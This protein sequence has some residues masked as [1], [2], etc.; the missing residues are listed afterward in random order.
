V[1]SGR[2]STDRVE[3][4]WAAVT[5]QIAAIAGFYTLVLAVGLR[6]ARTERKE[7]STGNLLLAGRKMP[8][9]VGIFTMTATWVGGGYI[10]G[11]AEAVYSRSQGLVWAQAPWGYAL[12]LVLG[13][14]FFAKPMRRAGYTTLLDP[15]AARYDRR[16]AAVLFFPALLGEV[17]WSAAILL[18][19]GTTF[20]A[21]F[22]L[23]FELSI[24]VSAAVAV[25]YTLCGGLWSVAWTD[26][27]Q[28]GLIAIGLGLAIPFAYGGAGGFEHVTMTYW[29]QMPAFPQGIQI[30]PWLDAALMLIL[31]GIPWQVYFQRVLACRTP[32]AAARLSVG[33][34]IASLL[35]ALPAIGL[36]MVASVVDWSVVG[37]EPPPSDAVVLPYALKYL[38][39]PAVALL[40]LGAISAAV[41][42]SVDS[43][44]LSAS[45]LFTWNVYRPLFRPGATDRQ[46]RRTLRT[47]I[48]LVGTLGTLLA[49]RLQSVYALWFL[50]ADL[51]YVILFP[52]L[53]TALFARRTSSAGAIA[54]AAV[55]L[56]ARL[57]G[58]VPE[59]GLPCWFE[60]PWQAELGDSLPVRTIA[61]LSSWLTIVVVSRMR[62]PTQR[63]SPRGAPG[64]VEAARDVVEGKQQRGDEESAMGIGELQEQQGDG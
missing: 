14:W 50:C 7:D 42:S 34:G 48:V 52:Q 24:I 46:L 10:N 57:C 43:S 12:S 3:G 32:Q 38:T 51:A 64:K 22:D 31:G 59:L 36:G 45:S 18:A 39:P 58:G 8:L 26:V 6:A 63:W 49:L 21:V 5:Y 62:P 11:T 47:T 28:L 17:F 20:A 41:M 29:K 19:L 33:S 60:H 23:P 37:A 27:L 54:G 40:G 2:E 61:M 16:V 56:L 55:G 44:I 35:M 30:W 15:F 9:W 13:G 1:E 25:G 53:V 4:Y